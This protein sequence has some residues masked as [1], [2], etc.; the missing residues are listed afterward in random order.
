MTENFAKNVPH[1]DARQA[2]VSTLAATEFQP[3]RTLVASRAC[4]SWR[5]PT[6]NFRRFE[7]GSRN[8]RPPSSYFFLLRFYFLLSLC[9]DHPL[10]AALF[11][12][13]RLGR[14][15]F[16]FACFALPRRHCSP[17]S[18]TLGCQ[19][20]CLDDQSLGRFL[21]LFHVPAFLLG[22]VS[23]SLRAHWHGRWSH[24]RIARLGADSLGKPT[25]RTFLYSEPLA[26]IHHCIRN[27][28]TCCVRLV[29]RHALG[30]Q[31]SW[32]PELADHGLR[33]PAFPGSRCRIDRLLFGLLRW[34]APQNRDGIPILRERC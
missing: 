22:R 29:A 27:R 26:R 19:A 28:R 10:C 5:V 34:S 2:E 24:S 16:T 31:R 15:D 25:G 17:A 21:S 18:P 4:S 23:L 32:R 3:R 1:A 14:C 12:S 7:L 8:P 11:C 9:A 20:K 33:Y 13:A 6:V 30:Q